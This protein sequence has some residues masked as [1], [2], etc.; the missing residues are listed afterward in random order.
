MVEVLSWTDWMLFKLCLEQTLNFQCGHSFS[1]LKA[2]PLMS[3]SKRLA[4]IFI[5]IQ[6]LTSHQH[7]QMIVLAIQKPNARVGTFSLWFLG[8]FI[9]F[10]DW[11]YGSCDDGTW[12]EWTSRDDPADGLDDE[13]VWKYR[14]LDGVNICDGN[15][16]TSTEA[17]VINTQEDY[18]ETGQTLSINP[19]TGLTCQ[20]VAGGQTCEDYEVRFCCPWTHFSLHFHFAI[21]ESIFYHLISL[22]LKKSWT[23]SL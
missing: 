19:A 7:K 8:C 4:A 9:W 14:D 13:S 6:L 17:R 10:L 21:E 20:D 3:N 12:T 11:V 18:T 16:P 23:V 1:K 22:L 2:P 5:L 15:A